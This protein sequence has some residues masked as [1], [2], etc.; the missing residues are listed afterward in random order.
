MIRNEIMNTSHQNDLSR[1]SCTSSGEQS[2]IHFHN[3]FLLLIFLFTS[4]LLMVSNVQVLVPMEMY[5]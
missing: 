1:S 3:Q 5:L 4:L 2:V